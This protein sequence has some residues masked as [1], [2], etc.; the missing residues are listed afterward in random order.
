MSF[1]YSVKKDDLHTCFT[2]LWSESQTTSLD[3][4]LHEL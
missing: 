3:L 2:L 1:N 4:K